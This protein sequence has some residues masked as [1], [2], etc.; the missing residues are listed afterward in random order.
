MKKFT[1]AAYSG[2]HP[3]EISIFKEAKDIYE[4]VARIGDE[5]T[6]EVLQTLYWKPNMLSLR[7]MGRLLRKRPETV[8]RWL[9][10]YKIKIR[11]KKKPKHLGKLVKNSREERPPKLEFINMEWVELHPMYPERNLSYLLGFTVGDGFVTRRRIE[12]RNT[13]FGL[14]DPT[15]EMV[16]AFCKKYGSSNRVYYLDE[17]KKEVSTRA[18]A[19]M[20]SIRLYNKAI[21]SLITRKGEAL[22]RDTIGFL[23]QRPFIG[24]FLAG[25]WDADGTVTT[26]NRRIRIYLD[27][28][29]PRKWLLEKIRQALKEYGIETSKPCISSRKG[30]VTYLLGRPV[31]TKED[32]YRIIVHLKGAP[33]WIELVGEK[34]FHPKKRAR[35]EEIKKI[36]DVKRASWDKTTF[37]VKPVL[38]ESNF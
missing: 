18:E 21:V 30:R 19:Y 15:L 37:S 38:S 6:E 27:Q 23:L 36:L 3:P 16:N 20:W 33:K 8:R 29:E 22:R 12:M 10:K 1:A 26:Q 34:M 2:N 35:I 13:E 9:K 28:S 14:L 4:I 17:A 7:K 11:P 5:R 32:S 25:L 31:M 24:D